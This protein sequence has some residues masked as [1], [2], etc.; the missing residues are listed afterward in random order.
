[1]RTLTIILALLASFASLGCS[2]VNTIGGP[3]IAGTYR[4]THR[5][6]PDGTIVRPPDVEGLITFTRDY[7]NLNVTWLDADGDR[8]SRSGIS[9]YKLGQGVYS[10]TNV[11]YFTNEADGPQWDFNPNSGSA[12]TTHANRTLEFQLPLHE[13]PNVVFDNDGFT[14]TIH[15]QFIDHWERVN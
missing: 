13:E 4:L 12:P 9:R 5:E 10:E 14:A 1:M 15:G 2:G 3:S 8:Y 6:L 7:R 11:F